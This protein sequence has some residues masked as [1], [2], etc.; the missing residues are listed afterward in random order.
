M[1]GIFMRFSKGRTGASA[2]NVHYITREPATEGDREALLVR[3]YPDYVAGRDGYRD[4][5]EHLEEYARQR[6]EDELDR[7]RRGGTGE[8]R[9]HYRAVLSFESKVGTEQARAMAGEY[10]DR[11]FPDAPAVAAV[12]QDTEHTHIHVHLQARDVH[13]DKLHFDRAAYEHLDHEWADIYSREFGPDKA[14]EHE[15]KKAMTRE[16]KADYAQAHDDGRE[17]PPGL[18]REGRPITPAAAS[19]RE[20]DLYGRDQTRDRGDQ[21]ALADA[22]P[23]LDRGQR[24]LD[25]SASVADRALRAADRTDDEARDT[26]RAAESLADREL[27]RDRL[28]E[29]G[30]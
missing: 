20:G 26:L 27:E 3:N 30:R 12:H 13:G 2:A 23:E 22:Q 11:T 16:W 4:L 15:E 29:R 21:R 19:Q 17:P 18:E 8:V 6:E 24:A 25:G 10:L 7:P 9:T 14:H 28:E 1:P 5:R